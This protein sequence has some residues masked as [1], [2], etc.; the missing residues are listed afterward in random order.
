MKGFSLLPRQADGDWK[1]QRAGIQGAEGSVDFQTNFEFR[2]RK[3][4]LW[5]IPPF[6]IHNSLFDILLFSL[7]T[8]WPEPFFRLWDDF[9][10][11]IG[12]QTWVWKYLPLSNIIFLSTCG[13]FFHNGIYFCA[14]LWNYLKLH[15]KIRLTT[16]IY[17]GILFAQPFNWV[18][19][20]A[21]WNSKSLSMRKLYTL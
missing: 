9:D 1:R 16:P 5:S 4:T 10:T 2:T 18:E 17:P 11:S 8:P 7:V 3:V 21:G 20:F 12:V 19:G 13:I 15:S 6:D 14:C